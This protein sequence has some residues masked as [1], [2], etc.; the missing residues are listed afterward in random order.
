MR[1]APFPGC[2]T[3]AV[4]YSFGEHGEETDISP[5]K[6]KAY[7]KPWQKAEKDDHGNI[8]D[9]VKLTWFATSV[10]THNIAL[11]EA[12][13]FRTVA[14]YPGEQGL[15]HVMMFGKGLHIQQHS[16]GS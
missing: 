11:L 16:A 8:V 14:T 2:C 5:E 3:S 7:M 9:Q 10:N 15:V 4:I 13:G 6:I 12:A 1:V